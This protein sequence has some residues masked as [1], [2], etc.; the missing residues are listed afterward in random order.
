MIK[1]GIK[2]RLVDRSPIY[3]GEF[4]RK[5]YNK[6]FGFK[7]RK[8]YHSIKLARTK[9]TKFKKRHIINWINSFLKKF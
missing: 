2:S 7:K 4:I 9:K 8:K 3:K 1:H 5:A 6:K